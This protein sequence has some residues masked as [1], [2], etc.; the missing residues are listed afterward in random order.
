MDLCFPPKHIA[1][2]ES[3]KRYILRM[4]DLR[5]FLALMPQLRDLVLWDT[6]PFFDIKRLPQTNVGVAAISINEPR[7]ALQ[8]THSIELPELRSIEWSYPY[9]ADVYKFL[10]FLFAPS[11]ERLDL[12][13]DDLSSKRSDIA[14]YRG[15]D[16][17]EDFKAYRHDPSIENVIQ[18]DSLKEL[19]L[20]CVDDDAI[21]HVFRHLAFPI[22]EKVEIANVGSHRR[23][24]SLPPTVFPRLESIFRDPRLPHLTHLILS[25][26]QLDPEH[27]RS[28]LGYMPALIS[29]SLDTCSGVGMLLENLAETSTLVDRVTNGRLPVKFCSRLESIS[30]L[31]CDGEADGLRRAV[32]V[33]NVG[34]D[35]NVLAGSLT[36]ISPGGKVNPIRPM[37]KLRRRLG[38]PGTRHSVSGGATSIV[39]PIEAGFNPARIASIRIEDCGSIAEEEA[40]SLRELGVDDVLW[41]NTK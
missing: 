3:R 6:I 39:I 33:R 20:Q 22:L 27:V 19:S 24:A 12:F 15:Y 38:D 35:L 36:H 34:T 17:A 11:L 5:Q 18:L 40:L 2:I 26:F 9:P 1:P 28:M 23:K 14:L 32:K 41:N 13:L 29:L 31:A 16:E 37:K 25:H 8:A 10:G 21:T 30:L 7:E 4:S